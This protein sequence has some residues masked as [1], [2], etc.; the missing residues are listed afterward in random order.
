MFRTRYYCPDL[1]KLKYVGSEALTAVR[2]NAVW[3]VKSQET[4]RRNISL[5]S[6]ANK[7]NKKSAWKQVAR[8]DGLPPAFTL[9]SCSAHSSTTNME[10]LCS[11][12][13]L[14][15]L[16]TLQNLNV[17]KNCTETRIEFN[18]NLFSNSTRYMRTRDSFPSQEASLSRGFPCYRA[19][20]TWSKILIT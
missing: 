7:L 2:Y 9:V 17:S 6:S 16:Q 11:S 18:G 12:E 10:T 8:T 13:T 19:E 20:I 5:P 1:T 3:S 14:A 4:F 15:D